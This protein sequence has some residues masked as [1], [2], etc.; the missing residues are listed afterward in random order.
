MPPF[1]FVLCADDFGMSEA[2]S[3]GLLHAAAAGRITAASAMTSLPDWPRAARDWRAT[4]PPADLGLH[5]TLTVGTPLGAMPRLAPS[6]ELPG[7]GTLVAGALSGAL[8]LPEIEAEIGRQI[9]C[10]CD[11]FGAAPSHVDGH[12][13]VHVLPGVRKALFA[14]LAAR[15]MASV[16]LRD[17]SDAPRRIAR[18]RAFA[19]KALK[20]NTLAAGYR[21]AAHRAGHLLNDGFAGFSD[22]VAERY[23]A[24][25]F[26][27]YLKAHGGR[28]LVMCHPGWTDDALRRLDPVV[29]ARE[30]ELAFLMSPAFL[31][32][33]ARKGAR[34]KRL[35]GWLTP[36]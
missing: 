18:R 33:L 17:S 13:H 4:R 22:F 36:P 15:G 10:F 5:V 24:A 19:A 11:Q 29:E 27:S 23:G 25:Q 30:A 26:E 8:P 2:V 14:A 32:L 21:R 31:E 12:Q 6:G 35:T 3:R 9:D 20:V 16:V 7:L 34:L 28:H 1:D